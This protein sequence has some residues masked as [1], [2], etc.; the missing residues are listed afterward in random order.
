MVKIEPFTSNGIDDDVMERPEMKNG[1]I[2]KAVNQPKVLMYHRIVDD[3]DLSNHYETCLHID[4]FNKQLELLDMLEYTPI[5]LKDYLLFLNDELVLPKKPII[6]TFDDG[7]MDFYRLAY[8]MLLEYGMR[9]VLFVLGDRN[10]KVNYWDS[11]NGKLPSA[12]LM[13]DHHIKE[14]H[15]KGFEIGAHSLSHCNLKGLKGDELRDEILKPKILLESLIGDEVSSCSYPYGQV[16]EKV[17][18]EVAEAGYQFGCSVFSGPARFGEDPF[19]I[20]R[21]AIHNRTSIGGFAMRL[22]TP[23]EY[24]EWLW[25]KVQKSKNK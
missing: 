14:L 15:E 24:A 4:D 11:E 2:T 6:L 8:P 1:H 23:Y 16:D 20:R 12:R 13:D 7:Y 9:S 22:V 5:T 18:K 10:I 21:M 3:T 17:K 25:A 19:E